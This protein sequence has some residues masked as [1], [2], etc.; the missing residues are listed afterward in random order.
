[1]ER[2]ELL[3]WLLGIS[4]VGILC[5]CLFGRPGPGEASA[6][7]W[8]YTA[9]PTSAPASAAAMVAAAV[10]QAT[11]QSQAQWQAAG[12][13]GAQPES[14]AS[15]AGAVA[16]A[17][18]TKLPAVLTNETSA[19]A[20]AAAQPITTAPTPFVANT[21]V[22]QPLKDGIATLASKMPGFIIRPYQL[23]TTLPPG[24]VNDKR[25]NVMYDPVSL[26]IS[27]VTTG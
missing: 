10:A 9:P 8:V 20:A 6:F 16:A 4:F 18:P 19:A 22:S 27:S 23:G 7:S 12:P 21:V 1:M 25:L 15:T 17:A 5:V 24:P 14:L 11:Q 26:T 3:T 13:R 2:R